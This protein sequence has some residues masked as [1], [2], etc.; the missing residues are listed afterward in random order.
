VILPAM[1][2]FYHRPTSIDEL[3]AHVVGKVLDRLGLAQRVSP[4]WQGLEPWRRAGDTAGRSAAGGLAMARLASWFSLVKF[5]HSLFALPFALQG[6]WLARRGLPP[7]STLLWIVGSAVAAR[8]AAMG[9]NRLVDRDV[10]AR[11]PRTRARELPADCSRPRPSRCS[12]CSRARLRLRRLA[13][14]PVVRLAGLAGAG[15]LFAYSAFK[16]FSWS[17][18][19]VLGLALALAPLAPGCGARRFG[20]AWRRS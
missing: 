2:G 12:S 9:F 17:A 7:W 14:E 18:H 6:A 8:T 20:A 4:R 10:D 11:N 16:R 19:F 3:V 15:I 13:P 5:S 1:P